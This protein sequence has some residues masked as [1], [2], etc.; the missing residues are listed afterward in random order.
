MGIVIG[1]ILQAGSINYAMMIFARLFN[2]IFNGM[3]TST[4]PAYQAECSKAATR[5]PY[6]MVSA[7]VNIFVGPGLDLH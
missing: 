7:T 5:G 6:L 2:G 3:L 4:V 1:T